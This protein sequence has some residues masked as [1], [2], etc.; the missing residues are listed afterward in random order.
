M[1][2]AGRD[3]T[4]APAGRRLFENWDIATQPEDKGKLARDKRI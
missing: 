3:S 4:I 2:A 1:P